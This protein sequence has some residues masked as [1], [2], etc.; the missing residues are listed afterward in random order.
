T[1]SLLRN[2]G[3]GTFEPEHLVNTRFGETLQ[4]IADLDG[5]SVPD[6]VAS[7]YWS[8]GIVVHR[9]IASEFYTTATH[10]GPT[11]VTD[12]AHDGKRDL[13]SFS[14]GSGNPVRVHFFRGNGDGTFAPKTT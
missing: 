13:V 3:D 2:R 8:N 11:L 5:D 6:V 10:G 7:D 9:V 12:F 14:F 4:D 1:F